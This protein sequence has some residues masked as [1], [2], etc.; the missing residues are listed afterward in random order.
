MWR[1]TIDSLVSNPPK[2][3][4]EYFE[5]GEISRRNC[6]LRKYLDQIEDII[7]PI[8]GWKLAPRDGNDGQAELP[9][10]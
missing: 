6:V 7:Y 9:F 4:E 8:R 2:S 5:I 1:R 10:E 3:W